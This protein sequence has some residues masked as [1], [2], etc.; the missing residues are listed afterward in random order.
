[1]VAVKDYREIHIYTQRLSITCTVIQAELC[2]IS[3]AV[4]WIESQG[5]KSFFYA[6]NVD[7]KATL[8]AI[9]NKHTTHLF[10][11]ATRLKTIKL[12][13]SNSITFHWV[14]GHAGLK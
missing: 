4:D 11:V 14:K 2:G 10:A 9:A 12:R 1:M 5:K 6:T 8:L 3:M 13:N 7:S